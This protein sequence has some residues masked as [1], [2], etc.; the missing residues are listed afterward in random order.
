[1]IFDSHS[2]DE[3]ASVPKGRW[4][5]AGGVSHRTRGGWVAAPAGVAERD[6]GN[7]PASLRRNPLFMQVPVVPLRSTTG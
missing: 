1:M 5:L 4:K 3:P 6:H 2:A 7:S